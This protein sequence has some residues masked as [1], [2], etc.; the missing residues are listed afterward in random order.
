M[1]FSS[2]I[3]VLGGFAERNEPDRARGEKGNQAKAKQ[4]GT[5]VLTQSSHICIHI[6]V[7]MCLLSLQYFLRKDTVT[8]VIPVIHSQSKAYKLPVII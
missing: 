4:K 2:V 3:F 7:V 5:W 8:A 6:F 1:L